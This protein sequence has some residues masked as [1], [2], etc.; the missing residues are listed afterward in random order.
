MLC[1]T[2][3]SRNSSDLQKYIELVKE[4]AFYEYIEQKVLNGVTFYDNKR[5]NVKASV[6]QVLFTDNRYI[7]QAEA[8]PKRVFKSLF[9]SVYKLF[10]LIKKHDKTNLP[11]LLQRI[12]SYLILLVIAK[13][14]AR[15]K[16]KLPIF[17]IHDSIITTKQNE[18]YVQ[19]I[20]SEE[21]EKAI[22]FAPKLN[23]EF[24]QPE[25]LQFSDGS[26]FYQNG[27]IAA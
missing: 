7:G 21:M 26:I 12:E 25:N 16:S 19:S 5:K 1:K 3:E 2:F 14:I 4:G 23:I 8:E 20:I 22:G 15:E 9:P 24:W 18:G 17:T 13:R 6:F 27:Q 10:S 11:R